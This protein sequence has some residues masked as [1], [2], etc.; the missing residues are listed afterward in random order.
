MCPFQFQI[1][2]IQM[3]EMSTCRNERRSHTRPQ[4]RIEAL[5]KRCESGSRLD[6]LGHPRQ[7]FLQRLLRN[8]TTI[9]KVRK[10]GNPLTRDSR[11]M[12]LNAAAIYTLRRVRSLKNGVAD[13]GTARHAVKSDAA[14][15]AEVQNCEEAVKVLISLLSSSRV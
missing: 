2:L 10:H 5:N 6:N 8:I 15:L 3:C 7:D 13:S 14:P 12:R 1:Q 11:V 4:Q 9:S